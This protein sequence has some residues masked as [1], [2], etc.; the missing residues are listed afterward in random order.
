MTPP[1]GCKGPHWARYRHHTENSMQVTEAPVST[2]PKTG[3]PS[4]VSWPVIGGPTAHPTEVTLA[5]GDPPNSLNVHEGSFGR[6][7]LWEAVPRPVLWE[8]RERYRSLVGAA[9]I[10]GLSEPGSATQSV[11]LLR[12][13]S[14][15]EVAYLAAGEVAKNMGLLLG[16][17]GRFGKWVRAEAVEQ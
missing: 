14:S 15:E 13:K 6:H 7:L 4:R 11:P 16:S 3:T 1:N 5:S 12:I 17:P 10:G 9:S 8:G 2:R